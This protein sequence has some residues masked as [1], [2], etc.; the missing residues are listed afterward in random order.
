[1][2]NIVHY[3]FINSVPKNIT[4]TDSIISVKNINKV[5]LNILFE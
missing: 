3:T 5:S 1:M 2:K 4:N